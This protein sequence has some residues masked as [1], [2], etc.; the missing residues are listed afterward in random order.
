MNNELLVSVI[1]PCY[2]MGEFVGQALD[3]IGNQTCEKWEVIAVDDCG[4]EDGT[5]EMVESFAA[6]HPE[7]RVEFIRMPENRG[8]SAAR[9]AGIQAAKGEFL[10][11]LDPDDFW[12][13]SYLQTHIEELES[14]GR[15]TAS[16]TDAS[17]ITE[18]G[19]VT[20]ELQG[21]DDE[22]H[23]GLPE[24]LYWRNFINTS[25]VVARKNSVI[26]C[27]G[28]DE[29]SEIQHVEDWDL[30]LRMMDEGMKFSYTPMAK[31]FYR[32]HPG[33]STV[34]LAAARKR[35]SALRR[36]HSE[37]L[38]RYNRVLLYVTRRRMEQLD[39]KQQAYEG[40]LLFRLSRIIS[41]L[42]H[43]LTRSVRR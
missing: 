40:S 39:R 43:R 34:D 16:Y 42:Y 2:K 20:G 18:D 8:V 12:G 29:A 36:K 27:G 19:T 32:Q 13:E 1:M 37:L 31:S 23:Q 35:E 6:S 26:A 21:P 41:G 22:E 33:A 5:R 38:E 10:A 9:N 24:S 4:P 3:S 11:F 28:F 15:I 7:H 17:K 14:H 25:T 30:W